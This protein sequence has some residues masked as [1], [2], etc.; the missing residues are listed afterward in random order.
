MENYVHRKKYV[1][2]AII[3]HIS[4]YIILTFLVSCKLYLLYLFD[5]IFFKEV[6]HLYGHIYP[7]YL[8]CK[9]IKQLFWE[10][11]ANLSIWFPSLILPPWSIV[12]KVHFF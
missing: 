3:E 4:V 11:K 12:T 5:L 6:S 2:H 8:I 9:H 7:G 10:R 1:N